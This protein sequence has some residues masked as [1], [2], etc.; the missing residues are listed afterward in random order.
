M[1]RCDAQVFGNAYRVEY[2]RRDDPNS[3]ALLIGNRT[4]ACKQVMTIDG[5][6][7]SKVEKFAHWLSRGRYCWII[8]DGVTK[9]WTRFH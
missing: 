5:N 6:G 7:T 3:R 9:Q 4:D 2:E 1:Y 8:L